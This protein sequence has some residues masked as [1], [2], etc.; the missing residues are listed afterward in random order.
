MGGH[1]REQGLA[2][3]FGNGRIADIELGDIWNDAVG[4]KGFK[5]ALGQLGGAL[6]SISTINRSSGPATAWIVR[7]ETLV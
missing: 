7:V 1:G 3:R 4:G 5:A 2:N 6:S